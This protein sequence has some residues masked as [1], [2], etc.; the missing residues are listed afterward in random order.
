M[1]D[2]PDPEEDPEEDDE[3][4]PEEDPADYPADRGDDRDDEEPSDDDDAEEEEHLAPADPAE[5][6]LPSRVRTTP[7]PDTGSGRV[8][9][10]VLLGRL[11][12]PQLGQTLWIA[13]NQEDEIIYSQLDDARYDRAL[14]RAR[15][16]ML[17][18]IGHSIDLCPF[19]KRRR[20]DYLGAAW[21]QFDGYLRSDTFRGHITSDY[22]HAQAVESTELQAADR[23][24]QTVILDLLKADHRRQ[25]QLVEAL[26][27][28][29]SLKT[30]MIELQSQQGPAKDPA[31]PE[32]QRR[33][34][35]DLNGGMIVATV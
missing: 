31:K 10:L 23:R 17:Y 18:R 6:L 32:H 20:P 2:E 28:V 26:K 19:L 33:P 9:Q 4:D 11:D 15:V 7:G 24:R 25:R 35:A 27:I 34:V 8:R 13:D 1:D 29:K 3:E 5:K 14:L 12:L 30:Q 21:A 22:S 16:N